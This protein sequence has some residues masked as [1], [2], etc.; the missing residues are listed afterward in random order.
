MKIDLNRQ[1]QG[2]TQ[3]TVRETIA[4]T[5]SA[6]GPDTTILAGV[7]QVDNLES[8]LVATGSLTATAKVGCDR[9]LEIFTIEFA[10]PV[11][12]LVIKD[13]EVNDEFDSCIIH[14]KT[15]EIDLHES[16][17]EASLLA[18]PQKRLCREDCQGI[19]PQCGTNRNQE[20]CQCQA[21]TDDP[22]WDDL[23]TD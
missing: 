11:E 12:L 19:C 4:L 21:T 1:P 20:P 8:R 14:Q 6:D 2:R 16:L 18:L 23:P 9:C 15:G 5:D 10:V 7:L 17:R 13:S 22:R 3:V